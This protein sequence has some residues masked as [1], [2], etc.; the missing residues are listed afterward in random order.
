MGLG[1]NIRILREMRG[2]SQDNMAASLDMSQAGYGKIERDE[3]SVSVD[4]LTKI[5]EILD[6]SIENIIGFDTKTVFNNHNSEINQ[7][8]GTYYTSEMKELYLDKIKLLED[9]VRLLEDR[10]K[11]LTQ[12]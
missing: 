11:Q 4:K 1:S 6:T 9:K 2:L 5:A 10:I 8:I 7:Q 3:V 12:N